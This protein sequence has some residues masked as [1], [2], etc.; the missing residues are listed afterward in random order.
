MAECGARVEGARDAHA[1]VLGGDQTA[2]ATCCSYFGTALGNTTAG[3]AAATC[4]VVVFFP[5][6]C[7]SRVADAVVVRPRSTVVFR[8]AGR[9]DRLAHKI[10]NRPRTSLHAPCQQSSGR[11]DISCGTHRPCLEPDVSTSTCNHC[12]RGTRARLMVSRKRCL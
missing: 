2:R 10:C 12:N 6:S 3:T 4:V 11:P 5:C 9:P 1:V 8:F 7:Y